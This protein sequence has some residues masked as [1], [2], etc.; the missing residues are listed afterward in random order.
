MNIRTWKESRLLSLSFVAVDSFVCFLRDSARV[1][2][3]LI[4]IRNSRCDSGFFSSKNI[5]KTQCED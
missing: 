2:Y 4:F 3:S 5:K 1:R